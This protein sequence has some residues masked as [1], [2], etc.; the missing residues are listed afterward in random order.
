M[1]N[2]KKAMLVLSLMAIASILL[3]AC[4]PQTVEVPATVVV[5]ETQVVVQEVT[6]VVEVQPTPIP[7]E[8][9]DTIIV[10]AWHLAATEQFP[11]LRQQSGDPG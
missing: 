7:G 11:E 9:S 1:F 10:G 4:T 3:A 5:R 6:T 2:N 8:V